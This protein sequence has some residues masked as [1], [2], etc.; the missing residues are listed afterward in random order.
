[1]NSNHATSLFKRYP[2]YRLEIISSRHL[3]E[4]SP[5][6][7][8]ETTFTQFDFAFLHGKIGLDLSTHSS[9]VDSAWNN[10]QTYMIF[11]TFSEKCVLVLLLKWEIN[12]SE[13]TRCR[14]I[15]QFFFQWN[16]HLFLN[17]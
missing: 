6:D 8:W 11:E 14:K 2:R 13:P 12:I 7:S 17:Q 9:A 15:V 4:H 10:F 1:M 16:K 5:N 3:N